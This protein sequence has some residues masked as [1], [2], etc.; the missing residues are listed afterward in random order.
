MR[1]AWTLVA[2][3]AIV[4]VVLG[5]SG[6]AAAGEAAA[7]QPAGT[8]G[9]SGAA[10]TPA[11]TPLGFSHRMQGGVGLIVGT[12]YRGLVRYHGSSG[13]CEN[14]AGS[15][16][17]FCHSRLPTFMDIEGSFGVTRA[18]STIVDFRVGFEE[19]FTHG[20]PLALAPGIK[21]YIDAES[22]LKFFITL[23]LAIDFTGQLAG[24]PRTDIGVRNA[25][26]LQFDVHRLFGFWLQLGDT[27]GFRRYFRFEI[28]VAVGLE[29][30]FPP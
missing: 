21:Y 17:T 24:V 28:D 6:R 26:G 15:A 4:T 27:L 29:A 16:K 18:L 22:R 2:G 23:Q 30:R 8:P 19:D 13:T 9:A 25:V 1:G 11:E 7:S 5:G 20:R 3:V 14:V 10:G 12:G